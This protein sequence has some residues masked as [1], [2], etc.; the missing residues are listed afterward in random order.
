M[1][2]RRSAA[3]LVVLLAAVPPAFAKDPPPAAAATELVP[4]ADREPTVR[5]GGIELHGSLPIFAEPD[6]GSDKL[7][8]GGIGGAFGVTDGLELGADYAFEVSPETDAA[9]VLAGHALFRIAHDEHVSAALGGAF[10]YSNAAD[11]MV[12]AGGLS[13]RYRLSKEVSIF[14]ASSGIPLCGSCLQLLG[15][16]TGQLLIARDNDGGESLV[17]LSLPIGIGIQASPQ[18]YLF[19]ETVLSTILLSPES[20][21]IVDFQDYIGLHLGGWISASKNLDIGGGFAND[22][23]Q[24]SDAYLIELRA[25]LLL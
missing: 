25:R 18:V 1:M 9:G 6:I 20:E 24:A 14:S 16:V 2:M 10:L 22:L 7:I 4:I 21:S 12:F 11:G 23:K 17:A 5:A 19:G 8:L 13:L 3:C 15:P